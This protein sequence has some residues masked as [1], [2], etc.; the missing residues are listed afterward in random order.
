MSAYQ[1]QICS[2]KNPLTAFLSVGEYIIWYA[3]SLIEHVIVLL[4]VLFSIS[5]RHLKSILLG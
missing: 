5:S 1:I 2:N 4:K 3:K